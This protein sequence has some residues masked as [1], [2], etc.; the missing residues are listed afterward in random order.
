MMCSTSFCFTHLSL[1]NYFIFTVFW[2]L[3]N[4]AG[5]MVFG[6]F[7]W[8]TER[9]IQQQL[10]VNLFGTMR[11]TKAVCPLL[12]KYRG[13]VVTVSSHCAT[14]TLPGLAVYGATKAGISAW[15]DGLRVELNKYGV[16]VTLLVPGSFI[17]QSNIMSR[18]NENVFEMQDAM[19]SEQSEFYG[20]YFRQYNSYLSALSGT[21][22]PMKITDPKLY[23]IYENTLLDV[24]PKRSYKHEPWRYTFY[25]TLFRFSPVWLRDY[26]IVKFVQMPEWD[27]GKKI[28]HI[29]QVI[30]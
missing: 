10:D 5:V 9:L 6:E 27:R 17:Q 7:E 22:P 26:L 18:L 4:N 16:E 21:R 30:A 28:N 20:D 8:Q 13:R 19:T 11:I 23:E 2:A 3:V 14:A 24:K 29:A 25:H 12:R 15:N 1:V